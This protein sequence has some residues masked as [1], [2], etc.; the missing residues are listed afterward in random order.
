MEGVDEGVVEFLKSTEGRNY[1]LINAN[2]ECD[3]TYTNAVG[4]IANILGETVVG[5]DGDLSS[6]WQNEREKR[7]E[8]ARISGRVESNEETQRMEVN[9][10]KNVTR[11]HVLSENCSSALRS[12]L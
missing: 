2:L 1:Q 11:S 10:A 7:L 4:A 9:G 6:W 5:E 3:S 8:V 12:V